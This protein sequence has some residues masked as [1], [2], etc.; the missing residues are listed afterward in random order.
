MTSQD[1]VFY[2]K[3]NFGDFAVGQV[4]QYDTNLIDLLD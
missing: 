4:V 1:L 3:S 2:S